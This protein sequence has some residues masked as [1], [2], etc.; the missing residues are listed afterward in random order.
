MFTQ[1][2][3]GLVMVFMALTFGFAQA[4]S[5]K[6]YDFG[7]GE[8]APGY[9]KVTAIDTYSDAKGYGFDYGTNAIA[10]DR[11]SKDALT[12]DFC[13]GVGPV[14]F[15]SKL[16][17]G[18]YKVTVTLGDK[19]KATTTTIKAESRRLM[20]EKVQTAPGQFKTVT[21]NVSV[22]DSIISGNKKV[23]LKSREFTSLDWDNKLTLEFGNNNPSID[24][25]T[26]EELPNP[27]QV[28]IMGNSTVTD[29][30]LSPWAS[31]GQMFP[32]FFDYGN[33]V[34]T[35]MAAS[36]AT[37]R[38]TLGRRRLDKV[39]AMLHKGD[40][41][42]IEFAHNDQKKGSGEE[43][44]TT[45]N[46]Y[47]KIFAD[48][49]RNHGAIPVF[50]TST[51]RRNFDKSGQVINTLGDF[52]AA[53]RLE[54]KKEN[55]Q[56]IDLTK[57]TKTL[58]EAYGDKESRKLFVQYPA[59]T[60]PDQEH[61]LEDNTH[62]CDFG[63]YEVAKCVVEGLKHSDLTLKNYLRSDLPAFDLS[64]PD[65]FNKWDLPVTPMFSEIK[66]YGN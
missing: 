4:Q 25:I 24:A 46:K 45:Y 28:F 58:Y 50:I 56:L 3:K 15:S 27:I 33:V 41:V 10:I 66:P 48:T 61:Q 6:K 18:N 35:N 36:G 20:V 49:A 40:Y 62:F 63:A 14:F 44:F 53:M 19:L 60:F 7:T 26:I 5:I 12:G 38:S 22:W 47:L 32:A 13:T 23:K 21:F 8:V 42:F 1:K 43:A 30:A 9:T 59:G 37:L 34:I 11:D 29:Q 54:A 57:M 64:H 65:D 51:N 52:P 39:A 17:Q 31:W 2:N 16:A 55:V